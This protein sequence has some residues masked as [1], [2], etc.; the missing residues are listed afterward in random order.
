MLGVPLSALSGGEL[1]RVM[2]ARALLR[3]PD[4]L[5]LDEPLAGVDVAGQSDLYRLIADLRDRY[6]CGVLMVSHDLHLVMAATDRVVCLNH[7]ICCTGRPEAI[8]QHPEYLALF[9]RRLTESLAVYSHHHDHHHGLSG[10]LD[11]EPAPEAEERKAG[12]G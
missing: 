10:D 2:L 8:S 5:V 11:D 4:L 1:H 3:E 9:G 7:H 12:R 6:R